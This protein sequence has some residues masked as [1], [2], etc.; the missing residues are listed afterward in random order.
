MHVLLKFGNSSCAGS[1]GNFFQL[2]KRA[3]EAIAAVYA[4]I[5][6][7]SSLSR[8][9]TVVGAIP[10]MNDETSVPARF[11]ITTVPAEA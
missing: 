8:T 6:H 7:Y 3:E 2:G 11:A 1:V 9:T 4:D 5:L 10:A